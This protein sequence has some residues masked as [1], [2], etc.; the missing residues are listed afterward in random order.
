[1]P[2]KV[3]M[4]AGHADGDEVQL[5]QTGFQLERQARW[6]RALVQ[7]QKELTQQRTAVRQCHLMQLRGRLFSIVDTA[8]WTAYEDQLYALII[9]MLDSEKSQVQY[10]DRAWVQAWA[11]R[12]AEF[13]P[14]M[15]KAV[16]IV[17]EPIP[18][19][20]QDGEQ[21]LHGD[22]SAAIIDRHVQDDEHDEQA[23]RDKDEA[24]RQAQLEVLQQEEDEM[25][26]R[27]SAEYPGK[28]G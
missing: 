26:L 23:M 25:L 4:H 8:A 10:E 21:E 22:C 5:M 1:M 16:K 19:D 24:T 11:E 27:Q 17:P 2:S 18:V 6:H 14:G 15:E 28:I 13:V 9:A 3:D 20:S 7:L 12:L